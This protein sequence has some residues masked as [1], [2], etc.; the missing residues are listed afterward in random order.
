MHTGVLYDSYYKPSRFRILVMKEMELQENGSIERENKNKDLII[1]MEDMLESVELPLVSRCC[2]YKVPQKIRK[3]NEAAYTPTIVSIGPFHYGDKR[4]QSMEELKLRYL[5]SFLERTQKGL[6]D[7]IEYIKESEE[8]IR[9]CYSETIEQSSDDLVRTVL[10]DACF[11]IEYFLRSLEWTQED[12]L[13]SKPWLR[14]D[15]KLDLILLENQ[16]PWFVLEEIF[17]LT[18]PSCFNGE[19]SSFFVVAFH[20]FKV[21]FLQSILPGVDISKFTI[22]H[23]HM[24]YQQYIMKPD[25]IDMQLHNL[26]DLLRVFYLPPDGMPRREKETVKHLYSASQL[27]EAGV[28]L[29][30][31]KNKSALEL[32]FEKGVLTIPRF[33][34]CHWTEILIRN[35]VAIEQCHYPFQTYITDY[36]FVFDFL[37]DTSQDVDTLVDKGIMIN[38]LGDSS[39]VANMVNNL[40]LN[41]VQENININGGYIYL[42]RKLNCFYEDPSHK[43]KA[44]FMHDYFSTPWKITSFIAAI[45]LLFLTLIQATCSVISLFYQ[46]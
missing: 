22:D 44:I 19:V 42:C 9:S 8:V 16:L 7:C 11:I 37:I 4:L 39:A 35:V 3:V 31:G 5:K 28:K 34:V 12:P 38:T 27:V 46:K 26:T 29:H 17:N 10:T 13:L 43:Y 41:V 1:Q 14:C 33:E 45:V 30:V 36:I 6:G 15:V 2:I 23:F 25:H 32:Q 20:Y 24:H 40:C 21:H 18:E